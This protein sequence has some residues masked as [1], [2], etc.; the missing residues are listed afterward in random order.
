MSRD[1]GSV[2]FLVVASRSL[3]LFIHLLFHSQLKLGQ[4]TELHRRCPYQDSQA[5]LFSAEVCTGV[6]ILEN[7]ALPCI[8][9]VG[10]LTRCL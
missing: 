9:T 5:C 2:G 1:D 8:A 4:C 10:T 7:E 3:W 6:N